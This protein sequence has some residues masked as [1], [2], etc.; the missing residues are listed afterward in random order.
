MLAALCGTRQS[1]GMN[2]YRADLAI[3]HD[4]GFG[5]LATAGAGVL[6]SA[7]DRGGLRR[8]T[9]TD[10]GCGSGITARALVDRGYVVV[11][12]DLSESLIE[13]ARTRVPEATFGVGSFVDVDVPPSTAVCAIGE[14]LNYTF[15]NRGGPAV[16]RAA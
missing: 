1:T 13:I 7:L 12:V 10:V 16:R 11:G 14:V 6:V 4:D 5:H 9:I 3:I 15:D 2:Y 8:G